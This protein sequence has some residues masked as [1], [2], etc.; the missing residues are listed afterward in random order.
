MSKTEL[1]IMAAKIKDNITKFAAPKIE[2]IM[3]FRSL[4]ETEII[5][6]IKDNT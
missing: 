2:T 4:T 1:I 5:Q 3:Y 6:Y